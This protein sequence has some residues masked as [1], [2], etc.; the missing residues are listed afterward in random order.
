MCDEVTGGA[1]SM[2]QDATL[3]ASMVGE[4]TGGRRN[5]YASHFGRTEAVSG[6]SDTLERE[7]SAHRRGGGTGRID[8]VLTDHV[9]GYLSQLDSCDPVEEQ[10]VLTAMV[11]DVTGMWKT[12]ATASELH[13]DILACVESGLLQAERIGRISDEQRAFLRQ[14]VLDLSD[15][16]L[17][18]SQ[19]ESN[20]SEFLRAQF[21][22]L[23]FA[24][25]EEG[26]DER[27]AEK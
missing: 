5:G 2:S 18:P 10:L 9:L 7:I 3:A 23:A 16:R 25:T 13:R 19:V 26:H 1:E 20:R 14:A 22:V 15:T 4:L 6:E 21:G 12:A 11:S 8:P 17:V 24:D 27:N